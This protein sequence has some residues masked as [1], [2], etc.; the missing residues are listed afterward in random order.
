LPRSVESFTR[1]GTSALAGPPLMADATRW[2]DLLFLSGRAAVDPASFQLRA[3]DFEGQARIVMEDC[4]AVLET[5]GSALEHVVRVECYL[6]DAGN[7]GAWNAIY[8]SY[9]P[10]SPPARTTLVSGFAVE[11]ML[12]EVQMTA[13][14]PS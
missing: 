9:F 8:S 4:I 12:V 14:V 2:G 6:A 5:C 7:F 11:G 13:G 10:F 1:A 3:Q